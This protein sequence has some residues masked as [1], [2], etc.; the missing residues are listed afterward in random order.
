MQPTVSITAMMTT[1]AA[2]FGAL[3]IALGQG[4]GAKSRPPLGAAIVG[5]LIVSQMC[6]YYAG[7][8][9]E[10]RPRRIGWQGGVLRV[11]CSSMTRWG[12]G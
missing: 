5:C 10:A 12:E 6:V 9:S 3:P 4:E 2:L 8:I 11:P 1:L 7:G